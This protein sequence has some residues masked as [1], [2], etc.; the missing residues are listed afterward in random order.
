MVQRSWKQGCFKGEAEWG[1]SAKAG[2]LS[3]HRKDVCS[4]A[5]RELQ[6]NVSGK[7]FCKTHTL[8]LFT[9][10]LIRSALKSI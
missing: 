10:M 5:R 8:A 3:S 1:L 2:L 4:R 9:V 7:T 6:I